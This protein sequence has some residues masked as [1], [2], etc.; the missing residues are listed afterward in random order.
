MPSEEDAGEVH[1]RAVTYMIKFLVEH[2][3]SLSNLSQ[4]VPATKSIHPVAKDE[5]V[6]MSVLLKDEKYI[7]DTIDILSALTD[8]ANLTGESQV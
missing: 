4:L 7:A 3:P 5:V 8:D 6:P 2:F 1:K